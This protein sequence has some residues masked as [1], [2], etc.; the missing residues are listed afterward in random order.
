MGDK[1]SRKLLVI[2]MVNQRLFVR[3]ESI[4]QYEFSF[5][6][7]LLCESKSMHNICKWIVAIYRFEG[8]FFE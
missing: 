7:T 8:I 3:A 5:E 2:A 4:Y 1:F 6:H